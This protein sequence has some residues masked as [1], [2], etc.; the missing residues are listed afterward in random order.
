MP[1]YMSTLLW[2]LIPVLATIG[3][4]IYISRRA[5]IDPNAD[6][7]AG[8][9]ELNRFRDSLS[10]TNPPQSIEEDKKN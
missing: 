3:A 4:T 1:A 5:K 6:I 8:V 10:A 7:A 9:N 2:L